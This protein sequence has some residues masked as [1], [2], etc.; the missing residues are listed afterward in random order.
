MDTS[1]SRVAD[2]RRPRWLMALGRWYL[3]GPAGSAVWALASVTALLDGPGPPSDPELRPALELIRRCVLRFLT[4]PST[5]RDLLE[6]AL[7]LPLDERARMA[8]DLLESLSEA[9]EGV[10]AAW[11]AARC[12]D[13]RHGRW[14]LPLIERP[15][16]TVRAILAS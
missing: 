14:H 7:E 9:E 13:E 16:E 10:E 5:S 15:A 4:M 3:G 12:I 11:T 6:K 8:A 2:V 1:P